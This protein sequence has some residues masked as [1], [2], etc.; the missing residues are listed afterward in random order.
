[1]PFKALFMAH[2]PDADMA[3]HRSLIETSLYK[4]GVVIIKNQEQAIEVARQMVADEGIHS[5]LLCPGFNHKDVAEIQ[6]VVGNEVA[7]GVARTDGP[8]SRAV[9]KAMSEVGWFRL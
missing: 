4:L 1:M 3:E 6:A 9:Q 8:G 2:A 7:I 5:I